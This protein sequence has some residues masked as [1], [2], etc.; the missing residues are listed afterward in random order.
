[1]PQAS[2][3]CPAI[4]RWGLTAAVSR[5]SGARYAMDNVCQIHPHGQ[6]L[7]DPLLWRS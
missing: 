1:M 2:S 6:A 3:F 5:L 7:T 4:F